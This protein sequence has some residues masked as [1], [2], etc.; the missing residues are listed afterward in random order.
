MQQQRQTGLARLAVVGL[1]VFL[2][3]GAWAG[4]AEPSHPVCSIVL[5]VQLDEV[6][7]TT[8][9]VLMVRGIPPNRP[10]EGGEIVLVA[11]DED[12]LVIE[13]FGLRDPRSVE[14]RDPVEGLS[15]VDAGEEVDLL[16]VLPVFENVA[17][18]ELRNVDG[19]SLGPVIDLSELL[20]D[21]VVPADQAI[22]CTEPGG[23]PVTDLRIQDWL[24]E[25]EA[26]DTGLGATLSH[27]APPFFPASCGAEGTTVRF[28][29]TDDCGRFVEQEAV[30]E[31][32]DTEAPTITVELDPTELWPPNHR[33]TGIVAT[34][35][36]K[37][38]CDE[39]PSIVLAS[40]ESDEPDN[41]NGKGD[42]NTVDDIQ[43]AE[44][45]TADFDFSLRAER[46]ATGDGR[47]Y[48]AT[49]AATDLCENGATASAEVFVPHNF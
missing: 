8:S 48:T 31:V 29:A 4:I 32:A 26:V 15:R 17:S 41:A 42:G 3:V 46:A 34:V 9:K 28:R 38:I 43:D 20:P 22:E 7:I 11:L 27:D 37:D 18:L 6:G 49:Y 12:G 30:L 36:A 45:G 5:D 2:V 39:S 35:A 40:V 10:T 13:R 33:M 25:A 16:I 21:L 14:V 24:A 19:T 44:P 1:A 23:V 47:T